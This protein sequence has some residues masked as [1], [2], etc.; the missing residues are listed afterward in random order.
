MH[1]ASP[2]VEPKIG[3]EGRANARSFTR[4]A[5]ASFMEVCP[6]DRE[7][8]G[9]KPRLQTGK[10]SGGRN[11]G[12]FTSRHEPQSA[13]GGCL[14]EAQY[15]AAFR[16]RNPA[17]PLMASEGFEFAKNGR[18]RCCAGCQPDFR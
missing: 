3:K 4:M 15:W 8:D 7:Q 16:P 13:L 10:E 5:G 18:Q 2:S 6:L 12:E 9:E 11:G 17:Q 1:I 14:A